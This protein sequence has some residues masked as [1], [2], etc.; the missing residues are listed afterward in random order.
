[1]VSQ[2]AADL[3]CVTTPKYTKTSLYDQLSTEEIVAVS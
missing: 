2:T 1:M 3:R